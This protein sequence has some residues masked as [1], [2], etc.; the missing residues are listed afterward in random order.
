MSKHCKS[1]KKNRLLCFQV[2][3]KE[4][5][6]NIAPTASYLKVVTGSFTN[7]PLTYPKTQDPRPQYAIV[8]HTNIYAARESK[9]AYLYH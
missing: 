3:A 7:F 5:F 1:N 2:G 9:R 4:F 6:F 8:D